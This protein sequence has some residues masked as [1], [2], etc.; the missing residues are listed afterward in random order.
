MLNNLVN[1]IRAQ[2]AALD[3]SLQL[4]QEEIEEQSAQKSAGE[5]DGDAVDNG[6]PLCPNC[7]SPELNDASTMGNPGQIACKNC[8]FVG[9]P[10]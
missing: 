1:A 5:S 9:S 4:L 2:M 7:E 8:G 10:L 6:A 3:Q